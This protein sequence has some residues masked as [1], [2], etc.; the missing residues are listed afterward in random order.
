MSQSF[1]NNII[2]SIESL[3]VIHSIKKFGKMANTSTLIKLQV[4]S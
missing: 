1:R 4:E 3:K 2:I